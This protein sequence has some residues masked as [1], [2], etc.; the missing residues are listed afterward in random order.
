MRSTLRFLSALLSV[1]LVVAIVA[2]PAEAARK[3]RR[4][5]VPPPPKYSAYVVDASSGAVLFDRSSNE[6]RYPAS[7]TKMMTLYLLFGELEAGRMKL[8]TPLKVSAH[9]QGQPPSKLGL[10]VGQTI[11]VEAA[12]KAL[13][14]NS[15]NDV[16]VTIGENIAGSEKDFAL[17]MTAKAHQLGMLKTTFRNASGLPNPQQ[18]TTAHDLSVLARHLIRDY[19]E[20][21]PYFSTVDFTWNGR[22]Y[23]THNALVRTYEGAEGLKTGYTRVSGFNLV[24]SAKRDTT[25][26]V[27]VV[28]GG[29]SVRTRDQHMRELL[30]AAFDAVKTDPALLVASESRGLTPRLKPTLVAEIVRKKELEQRQALERAG[31]ILLAANDT[32]DDAADDGDVTDDDASAG[33]TDEDAA[34]AKTTGADTTDPAS[35]HDIIRSLIVAS[36]D[37][38]AATAAP[39][40][41][42]EVAEG[43]ADDAV[44]GAPN[45]SVQIGAYSGK[46]FAE[47]ELKAAA[48][49]AHLIAKSR[50]VEGYKD[51]SGKTL[52]RARFTALT[53]GEASDVC[54]AL[55]AAARA[56]FVVS[57]DAAR[58]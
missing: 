44:S 5:A 23:I 15:A 16:A 8:D 58:R 40:A 56:C 25:R 57:A 45:W 47:K 13:V 37:G 19:P 54:D 24:T 31:P 55:K 3:R 30:D 12:I 39:I 18:K 27:G 1:L 9:A 34:D 20:Y 2:T 46:S 11:P 33:D 35:A 29:R 41:N 26:L 7:L 22:T 17:R 32:A 6:L 53:A 38:D 21:Y 48:T 4:A 36:S 42:V 28:M 43:D 50:S 14:V 49:D 51:G 10:S 52:Y